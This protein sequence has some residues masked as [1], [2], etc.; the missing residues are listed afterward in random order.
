MK[1]APPQMPRVSRLVLVV[2]LAMSLVGACGL[3]AGTRAMSPPADVDDL[4][5]GPL[6]SEVDLA[7]E[8]GAVA[9]KEA[10]ESDPN[11]SLLGA[12]N[13]VVSGML[14][15]AALFLMMRRSTA[16]WWARQALIGNAVWTGLQTLS[17]VWRIL[18]QE[19]ALE[20]V[21]REE[22]Q[23]RAAEAGA[24]AELANSG[25]AIVVTVV[26]IIGFMGCIRVLGYLWALWR[27]GRPDI[28]EF[29][30]NSND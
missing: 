16:I 11:R 15:L 29:L 24:G 23:L 19:D 6:S 10:L 20:G 21:F 18:A 14:M 4:S 17:Q 28:R 26:F 27:L 5:R 13:V 9:L 3:G 2:T 7:A 22:L 30:G 25:E 1:E 8:R 12:S